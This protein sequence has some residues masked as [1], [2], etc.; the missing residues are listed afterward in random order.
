MSFPS[1][2]VGLVC[3]SS[4]QF[5][6]SQNDGRDWPGESDQFQGLPGTTLSCSPSVLRSMPAG[7]EETY[8]TLYAQG[9]HP[10]MQEKHTDT[11]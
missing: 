11:F 8:T 6:L 7:W 3:E 2:S 9:T 5:G 1:D 10:C 4:L